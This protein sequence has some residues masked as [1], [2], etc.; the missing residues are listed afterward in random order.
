MDVFRGF[1]DNYVFVAVM[2]GTVIMQVLMV[3]LFGP[4]VKTVP[5]TWQEWLI[6][7]GLGA[8]SIVWGVFVRLF[9]VD[10]NDGFIEFN[11]DSEF[12][13]DKSHTR[14]ASSPAAPAAAAAPP[15]LPPSEQKAM[16]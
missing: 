13:T 9:K 1:F 5:L 12:L 11:K 10:L 16:N 15:V 4:F 3:T 2:G 14:V 6:C 7:V 8:T